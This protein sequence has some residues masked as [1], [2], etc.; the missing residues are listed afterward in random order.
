MLDEVF[1]GVFRI[2]VPLPRNPLRIINAYLVTG[3]DRNL[4]I[5]TGMNRPE[6]IAAMQAGL[7]ELAVDLA[8]T[9]IL[10]THCHSDH[11]GLV[12]L[13]RT[14]TSKVYLHPA[15]AAIICDPNLWTDLARAARTHGFPDPESAVEKHPGKKYLF[16]GRPDFAPLREG[17][18]LTVGRYRFRVIETPGHTPGHICLHE[19]QARLLFSGDHIL[20]N[21]TPN[22][23]GWAQEHEDPLGDFE[24]SLD[25]IAAHDIELVLPGHRDPIADHRRRI[26]EL[27]AHHAERTQEVVGIL[28]NGER[29]AYQV[30]SRMTWD[31]RCKRWEEFPVPQQ[32]FATGEALA[33][34]LHLERRGSITR[35]WREGTAYF[36]A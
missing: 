19:P 31:I 2:E 3:E 27:K 8:R 28:A 30:A 26:A 34:L 13:L 35:R 22:I 18:S 10:A 17:D 11:V 20:G 5:D 9:D 24:A 14:G 16:T 15:D 1:R 25:K 21:I 23:S 6:S 33:H 12:S 29:T 32:W 36:R 4:L 7:G